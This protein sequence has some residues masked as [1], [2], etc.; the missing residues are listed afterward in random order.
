M[1]QDENPGT[2]NHHHH[3]HHIEEEEEEEEE[4]YEEEEE[5]EEPARKRNKARTRFNALQFLED[6]AESGDA[7]ESDVSN[8]NI[9]EKGFKYVLF[10]PWYVSFRSFPIYG[11]RK[12]VSTSIGKSR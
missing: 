12:A 11:P 4:S 5:I 10:H 9:N 1:S 8:E 3:H 2:H 7:D 6:E